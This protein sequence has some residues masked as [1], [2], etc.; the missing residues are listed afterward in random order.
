[1]TSGLPAFKAQKDENSR[2]LREDVARRSPR[3][4]AL[5]EVVTLNHSD[6]CNLRCVM[7]PRNLAQGTNR[8]SRRVLGYI[9]DDEY[10]EVTPKSIRLHK[11]ALDPNE[12]KKM[13]RA[14][15]AS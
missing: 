15:K 3:F 8:L 10:V 9:A 14:A 4:R 2:L 12:R 13:M 6:L 5:P 1:M 7:C 11:I